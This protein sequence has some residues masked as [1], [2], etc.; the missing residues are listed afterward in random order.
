MILF[1]G[2][3]YLGLQKF[4]I[5]KELEDYL[6]KS[7]IIISNFE[8]VIED[9]NFVQRNDKL[10]ILTT[11]PQNLENYLNKIRTNHLFI[12]GNNHIHDLGYN[13][14]DKTIDSLNNFRNVT[15]TGIDKIPNI[16]KP[17]IINFNKKKI[18]LLSVSTD[19]PE[20]MSI[21]ATQTK[22]GVLDYYDNKIF[23]I[24]KSTKK[25]IDYFIIIPHWGREYLR[26]PSIQQRKIAY[27]WI[28]CGADLVVGHHPHVIQG[29]ETY[30][31]KSIYYSLGNFLFPEFSY[32]DGSIHSWNKENNSSII[33][34]VDFNSEIK[35]K[36]IGLNFNS[37]KG[38]LLLDNDSLIK[39]KNYSEYLKLE[40]YSFKK[41]YVIYQ[42]EL[43]NFL[44]K[45]YSLLNYLSKLFPKHKKY[46]RLIFFIVRL[47]KFI[48][49]WIT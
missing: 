27:R 37:K 46:N 22:K 40:K 34:Q 35:I 3:I 48:S 9:E 17:K 24:I 28:D 6:V 47:N 18:A 12:L 20:V 29:K 49:K 32:K 23:Q 33:L 26:Y 7:E 41:Y 13:G 1:T 10:S 5:D 2:D 11:N 36:E 19:D 44:K 15:F 45:E 31:G 8:N 39:F 30:K 42:K 25:T 4:N 38:K 21:L 14:I 43:Y 16:Y